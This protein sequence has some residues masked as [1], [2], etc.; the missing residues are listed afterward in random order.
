MQERIG[1][2]FY[3]PGGPGL[4]P[5]NSLPL[6]IF[7]P[8]IRDRFD[9][10]GVDLRG[11][12]LSQP[13]N[14]SADIFKT[15]MQQ[16]EYFKNQESYDHNLDL[17]RAFRQS[18]IDGSGPIVDYM[19]TVSIARDH[20]AVRQALGEEKLT[21]LGQSYGTQLGSHYAELFP[22]S[23][24]AMVL[25]ASVSISQS[26]T[27]I[28]VESAVANDAS[29][30]YFFEWCAAQNATVCPATHRNDQTM[31][32]I[33][34]DLLER[35]QAS[36]IPCHEEACVASNVT[37]ITSSLIRIGALGY[38]FSPQTY[39]PQLA[40]AIDQTAF[41][42]NASLFAPSLPTADELPYLSSSVYAR[43]IVEALDWNSIAQS[44][45]ADMRLKA[46]LADSEAPLFNGTS[47]SWTYFLKQS[48]G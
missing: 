44:S 6:S 37:S 34:T 32:E 46:V 21:W 31:A 36:P 40:L 8:E 22:N 13:V 48:L 27:S 19:D 45:P 41:E 39:Y 35:A 17:N 9:I 30:K 1:N 26:V 38:L 11:T 2:I 20:E 7:H 23:I 43:I 33:W 24:R 29:L 47:A 18:C 15:I 5:T 14:C 25:D 28:F 10:I 16:D 4:Q 3:N 12:G 42:D